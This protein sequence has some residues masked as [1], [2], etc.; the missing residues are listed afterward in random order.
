[1]D[2]VSAPRSIVTAEIIAVGSELLGSSRIDTNSLFLS[3]RLASLGIELRAKSVVGDDRDRLGEILRG[4]LSRADLVILTGG[5]GPTDDDLTREVV[6]DTLSLPLR[7]DPRIVEQI[8]ERFAARGLRMPHVNRR[9]AMVPQ[10]ATVLPNPRG[11]APGL[12]IEH[13]RRVIVLLPGPPREMQPMFDAVCASTLAPRTGGARI[14][15]QT[16][17]VAGR[18]E[19]HVEEIAQP[20]YSR[21]TS[22]APPIET[23]ILAMPGQVELHLTV[24]SENDDAAARLRAAHAELVTALGADVFSTDGRSMEEVVGA[25]LRDRR[26]TIAAAES[27]TG[28]LLLSRLTDIAGSSD[29]VLGGVV[30]Y[31][32]LLKTGLAGVAPPLIE[33]HGA[34]SEP[35]AAAL[36][37]GVRER[38][39]ASLGLGITGI[40]GPGGG[41]TDKPVGTVA[42]ALCGD[43][44]EPRVRTFSFFGGRP[45][46]KFQATQAALDMVRRGLAAK[47]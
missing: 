41:T 40:A 31:S 7:E 23:T 13:D 39:G 6:A 1:M 11:T 18:G 27:C 37:D 3:D 28:G 35:V 26:L 2:P 42:I 4:A 34:V 44:V 29:Y 33:A 46:V 25:M 32:N 20:I 19:S 9:Q 22:E 5:L 24:R 10:G 38:T 16:L 47:V 8:A 14:H 12:S 21:W 30:V 45:Q 15:K 17:F 43:G 36:A